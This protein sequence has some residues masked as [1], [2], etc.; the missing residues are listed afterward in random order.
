M[1]GRF[2]KSRLLIGI[3]FVI[4]S[5]ILIKFLMWMLPSGFGKFH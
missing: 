1:A 5:A 4:Y 2:A 3:E